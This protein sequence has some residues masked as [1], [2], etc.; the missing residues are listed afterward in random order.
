[1]NLRN[2]IISGGYELPIP[3]PASLGR[4]EI[5]QLLNKI[6]WGRRDGKRK[7]KG[8]GIG[9]GRKKVRVGKE[10]GKGREGKREEQGRKK[11]PEGRE[12]RRLKEDMIWSKNASTKV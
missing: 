3:P 8:K 5:H 4:R 11:R 1:M 12:N 9:K 7:G 2:H 6:K 10:R